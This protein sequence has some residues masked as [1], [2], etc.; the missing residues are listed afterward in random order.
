MM[1]SIEWNTNLACIARGRARQPHRGP[2]RVFQAPS[3]RRGG[4]YCVIGL[5]ALGQLRPARP[6]G[7]G[8]GLLQQGCSPHCGGGEVLLRS[9]GLHTAL[10]PSGPPAGASL[11]E[12]SIS[13][14]SRGALDRERA[15]PPSYHCLTY[16]HSR[17]TC[18]ARYAA[19]PPWLRAPARKKPRG[20]RF[21]PRARRSAENASMGHPL[22]PRPGPGRS[23][24]VHSPHLGGSQSPHTP[25]RHSGRSAC[26]PAKTSRTR[27]SEP[28][29]PTWI[30][31]IPGRSPCR[32]MSRRSIP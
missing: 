5:P 27:R 4:K 1:L 32:R 11:Q 15:R 8:P 17:A 20:T 10:P 25:A 23:S 30:A 22:E 18:S 31:S 29:R 28:R 24:P 21:L 6:W 3:L 13:W 16:Y 9:L 2:A 7:P 19:G 14:L 12:P 26:L